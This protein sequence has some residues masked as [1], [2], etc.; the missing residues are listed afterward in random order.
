MSVVFVFG[1]GASY[2]ESLRP[3]SNTLPA[4]PT[5]FRTPPLTTGFFSRELYDSIRY[6]PD[7]V[8]RD[9]REVFEYVRRVLIIDDPLGE[10][11]W[12]NLNL[13]VC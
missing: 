9:Y 13:A 5:N 4:P 11:R 12:G 3:T 1:A 8:E 6:A 7:T 2:G 10:G